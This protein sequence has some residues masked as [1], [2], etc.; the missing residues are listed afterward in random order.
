MVDYSDIVGNSIVASVIQSDPD[1]FEDVVAKAVRTTSNRS[2]AA[3][4]V[5]D[6][7]NDVLWDVINGMEEYESIAYSLAYYGMQSMEYDGIG[8]DM[9]LI[10]DT[11]IRENGP[12]SASV[13]RSPNG[14]PACKPRSASCKPKA[15]APAKKSPAKSSKPKSKTSRRR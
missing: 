15:K 4:K 9:A 14:R 7:V 3:S 5:E 2:Q 11:Y 10:V 13:R 12:K 6:Y 1:T 8:D